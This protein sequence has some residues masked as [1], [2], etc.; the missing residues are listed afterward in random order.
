MNLSR[1]SPGI[2]LFNIIQKNSTKCQIIFYKICFSEKTTVILPYILQYT[3]HFTELRF[4]YIFRTALLKGAKSGLPKIYYFGHLNAIY[5]YKEQL[6][7]VKN[8]M[9][10][11]LTSIV[12]NCDFSKK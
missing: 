8:R 2:L 6:L 1:S 3:I 5:I 4:I 9:N 11:I 12:Y 7:N 10:S